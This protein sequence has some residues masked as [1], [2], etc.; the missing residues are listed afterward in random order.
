MLALLASTKIH[1]A[2]VLNF[3]IQTN[4]VHGTLLHHCIVKPGSRGS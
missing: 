1:Q 2:P 4:Q 3:R